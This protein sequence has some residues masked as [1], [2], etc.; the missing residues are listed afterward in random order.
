[1]GLGPGYEAHGAL[2]WLLQ[3]LKRFPG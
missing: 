2:D 1:L 3:D